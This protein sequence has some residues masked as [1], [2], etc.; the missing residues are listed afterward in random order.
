MDLFK[1]TTELL[2]AAKQL[3]EAAKEVQDATQHRLWWDKKVDVLR[4]VNSALE[5]GYFT[6]DA[7]AELTQAKYII[8]NAEATAGGYFRWE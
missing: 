6:G 3:K 7:Y 2:E 4:A 5:T 8:S 1:T